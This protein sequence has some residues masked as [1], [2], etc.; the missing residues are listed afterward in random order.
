ML[1]AKLPT[2]PQKP[3]QPHQPWAYPFPPFPLNSSTTAIHSHA[4]VALLLLHTPLGVLIPL[5]SKREYYCDKHNAV[6][7]KVRRQVW[8][9]RCRVV[10]WSPNQSTFDFR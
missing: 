9:G 1:I 10:I 6:L 5:K 2:V 3:Q 8:I 4:A 7:Q